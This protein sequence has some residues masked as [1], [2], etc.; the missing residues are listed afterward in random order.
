MSKLTRRSFVQ[1]S[2]GAALGVASSRLLSSSDSPAILKHRET[3]RVTDANYSWEYSRETDTFQLYDSKK[4]LMVRGRMQPIVT[5]SAPGEAGRR[6]HSPGKPLEPRFDG[7]RITLGYDGV[8]GSDRLS[9]TWRFD[10]DGIWTEPLVYESTSEQDVVSLHYFAEGNGDA[11]APALHATYLVI[12]AIS[13]ASAISPILREDVGLQEN[14]C[15]GRGSPS[16]VSSQQWGLPVHYFC[17]FNVDNAIGSERNSFTEH[18]SHSFTCGLAD[19]PGGDLY[20]QLGGGKSSLWIN[21]R[22]DLW[23]HLRGPGPL[24]LGATLYWSVAPDYYQSIA[25]YYQGL[26]QAGVI[27]KAQPSGQKLSTAL[28]PQYC[29]WGAE[30][31]RNKTGVHLDDAFL[32]EI[33][34]ELKASG[35]KAG[36][37]SIDD[38]WEENYGHLQAASGRL[39]HF[40]QFLERLKS[41]GYKIGIWAAIM[42]CQHPE[43]LGL[44]IEHMLKMP[45]GQPYIVVQDPE[46]QYYILDFTQPEVARVLEQTARN[47]VRRYRPDLL[48][49]DFGYEMPSV[50]V[51]CP[52]DKRWA[53]ERMM[54]KGLDIVIH[55]MRQENPDLVVMYY[56]LSP[57]FLDYF[58][59]HGLDDLWENS[60]EYDFEANR[61][62]FFSSLLGRLGVPT[63]SSSGYDWASSPNIWFDGAAL[64][65][66]GSVNDFR[67]DERGESKRPEIIAK[68]NGLTHVLRPT[69]SFEIV[70]LDYLAEAPSQGAHPR[71]WAR[72]EGGKLVLL[73][74]RPTPEWE[75][76]PLSQNTDDPRIE[77]AVRC[78]APVVVASKTGESLASTIKLAIVSYGEGEI[79]LRR[80]SGTTAEIVAHYFGDSPEIKSTVSIEKGELKLVAK[81]RNAVGAPLEWIEVNIS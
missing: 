69:A 11:P 38:K 23:G 14:V 31:N 64:G 4:R 37:F 15:L 51:A 63:Y 10:E 8:N 3:P 12:P 78:V 70:P 73:A 27:H 20:L 57:L 71:S 18:K 53:G 47:F 66:I 21:Y 39:A 46:T 9:V 54:S 67:G 28:S 35:M 75:I 16:N 43:T 30:C 41:E 42:R 25:A 40:E 68:Y 24:K 5:V 62:F 65:A 48:K 79:V 49:F 34:E 44:T 33:Y 32:T 29:T 50:D 59:I 56:Q 13:A 26:L 45:N 52:R 74:L 19:L 22:S 7:S 6:R 76:N 60:G 36:L 77:N 81:K 61:R 17:G 72:I 55:A 80:E 2:T 58:D 1:C